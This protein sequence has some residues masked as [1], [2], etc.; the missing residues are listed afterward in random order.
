MKP[1]PPVVPEEV[2]DRLILRGLVRRLDPRQWLPLYQLSL[3]RA[4][5]A[6]VNHI[7]TPA[8]R[9]RRRT[10]CGLRATLTRRKG[11]PG[12]L[13]CLCFGLACGSTIPGLPDNLLTF[14]AEHQRQFISV[15]G[16]DPVAFEALR[17]SRPLLVAPDLPRSALAASFAGFPTED[18]SK[19]IS[20]Y[21]VRSHRYNVWMQKPVPE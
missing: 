9:D 20:C 17:T 2:T 15:A 14:I 18:H 3:H 21:F 6:E 11:S 13:P 7:A 4:L 12:R 16:A 10:R 1:R 5:V 8:D 19:P